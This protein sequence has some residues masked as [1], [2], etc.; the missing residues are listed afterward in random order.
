MI[1]RDWSLVNEIE[2]DPLGSHVENEPP[3]PRMVQLMDNYRFP[4]KTALIF[5]ETS[6]AIAADPLLSLSF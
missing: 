2:S 5:L 4:T 6:R 1:F 3:T